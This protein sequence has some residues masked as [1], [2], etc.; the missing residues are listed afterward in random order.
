MDQALDAFRFVCVLNPKPRLET[1][2]F[3]DLIHVNSAWMPFWLPFFLGAPTETRLRRGVEAWRQSNGV[4]VLDH[5]FGASRL[6]ASMSYG[7]NL[8]W[9]GPIGDYIGF[10]GGPI[11]GYTTNLVQ[12]FYVQESCNLS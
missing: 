9:S 1:H 8:G 11:K 12:G 5:C 2:M 10:W 6:R 3:W 7:L 4:K